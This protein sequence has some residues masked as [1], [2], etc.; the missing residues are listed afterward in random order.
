VSSGAGV[1]T[2]VGATV[3]V[4]VLMKECI[5]GLL[6]RENGV[7]LDCTLGGAGHSEAI[8]NAAPGVKLVAVDRDAR[9]ISRDRVSLIHAPFSQVAELAGEWQFDGVL[10]DLGM[11]SD[12]LAEQRG[13]SFQEAA[14]LDMRMDE[15]QESTAYDVVNTYT[16][17]QLLSVLRRGGCGTEAFG[18]VKAIIRA[19]PVADTAALVDLIGSVVKVWHGGKKSNPA[20]V[21][22][23]A[24]RIEV[25]KEYEEI[26]KL[27]DVIPQLVKPEARVAIIC[28]HSLEDKLVASR[29]R[30]WEG[31]SEKPALHPGY[32][33]AVS[34]GRLLTR[35]AVVPSEDE[36]REN[37]RSRSARLRV[38][39]FGK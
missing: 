4:P 38:F 30:D 18:L 5:D 1:E 16:D 21:V 29:M 28:F 2:E 11:S 7:Y 20:T 23:Q 32:T 36:A 24:L 19:R 15:S 12:Q 17:R 8:L 6:I 27:L 25:N 10:A 31:R 34:L 37:K 9:A 3:H 26:E 39:E 22:F 14:A 33:P 13:F 35:K